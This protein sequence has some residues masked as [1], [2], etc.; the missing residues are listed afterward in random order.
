MWNR[1]LPL[2]V[3][4]LLAFAALAQEDAPGDETAADSPDAAAEEASGSAEP[5]DSVAEEDGDASGPAQPE[6]AEEPEEVDDAADGVLD[7]AF[8]DLELD[9]QTYE[10]LIWGEHNAEVS[11][12]E[13]DIGRLHQQAKAMWG[14][15]PFTRYVFMIHAGDN[16]RGATEHVNSTIIQKNRW[17]FAPRKE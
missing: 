9:E 17:G 16:L 4:V 12:I 5:E 15:F 1:N 7:E 3:V 10:V 13:R 8:D 6:E 2:L 14:D 11:D